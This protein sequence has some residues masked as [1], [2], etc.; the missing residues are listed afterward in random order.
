MNHASFSAPSDTVL[1]H[2]MTTTSHLCNRS[3]ALTLLDLGNIDVGI[4]V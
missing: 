1:S 2:N 4:A 3:R